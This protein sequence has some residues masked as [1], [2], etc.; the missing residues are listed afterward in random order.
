M[1]TYNKALLIM[2]LSASLSACGG[3]G[4]GGTTL[5]FPL[6][7]AV[8][9][10]YS[11]GYQKTAVVSGT[12]L[13]SGLSIPVSGIVTLTLTPAANPTTF[14]GQDAL[15]ATTSVAGSITVNSQ[16]LSIDS[17]TQ[18]FLSPTYA[19]LG[20][21][22][23]GQYCVAAAAGSYPSTVT[24]GQ[25]GPIVSYNC[26]TDNTKSTLTGSESLSFAVAP[27]PSL[28]TATVSLIDTSFDLSNVQVSRAQ[29]NYVIDTAGN[30]TFVS[31]SGEQTLNENGPL[32]TVNLTITPQ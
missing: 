28:S 21:A 9:N 1:G 3:G 10:L 16:P 24:I 14:E 31:E 27:G 15:V 4:G 17:S 32:V 11:T 5:S 2:A 22:G 12:A 23:N 13:V 6:Q 20:Y 19:P 18:G 7:T 26:Y 8:V 25:T 30:Y 29:D